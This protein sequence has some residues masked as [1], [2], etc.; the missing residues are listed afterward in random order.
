MDFGG[1]PDLVSYL[2][3]FDTTTLGLD[4]AARLKTIISQLSSTRSLFQKKDLQITPDGHI[5]LT[6]PPGLGKGRWIIEA[7]PE[8]DQTVVDMQPGKGLNGVHDWW[9]YARQAGET[10]ITIEC[11]WQNADDSLEAPIQQS[12]TVEVKSE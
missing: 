6:D 12:L 4:A 10:E 8:K 1:H 11:T 2:K 5:M 3:S 7:N 9:I